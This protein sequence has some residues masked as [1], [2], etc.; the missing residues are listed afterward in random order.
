MQPCPILQHKLRYPCQLHLLGIMAVV[1]NRKCNRNS[2][3][4]Q[5]A[6]FYSRVYPIWRVYL[7]LLHAGGIIEQEEMAF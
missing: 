4:Y 6:T 3:L 5:S 1:A 2:V 7:K